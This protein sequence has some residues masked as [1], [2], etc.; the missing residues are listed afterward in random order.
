MNIKEEVW[1]PVKGSEQYYKISNVGRFKILPHKINNNALIPEKITFGS[2]HSAGYLLANIKNK[3]TQ[4]TYI[5][6]IVAEAFIPNPKNK[7]QVNHKNGIKTD[8]RVENLE[9]VDGKENIR[10][11]MEVIK[12]FKNLGKENYQA[13]LKNNE[14][15]EI[16]KLISLG[17]SQRKIAKMFNVAQMTICKVNRNIHWSNRK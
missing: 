14:Y 10:H 2:K 7:P 11:A 9:W 4:P 5:H 12:T 17:V 1:L 15:V 3:K 8:N 6:R 13:A 16:K